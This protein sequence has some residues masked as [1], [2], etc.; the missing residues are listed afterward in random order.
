MTRP[1]SVVLCTYNG[2][3]FLAEQVRSV[4]LQTYPINELIIAD[5]ASTDNTYSLIQELARNDARIKFTRNEFN[6]GFSANFSKAMSSASCELIAISDQDDIWHER[7]LETLVFALADTSSLIY[8]N[9]IHFQGQPIVDPVSNPRNR[10]IEGNDPK[11]IAVF[12]TI[13]GHAMLIRKSLLGMALPVP[14]GVYYDWWLALWAMT[15]GEIQFVPEVLVQQRSHE[16]N[17]TI[18][19]HLSESDLRK[20]F[21]LMLNTHLANFTN[22][23]TFKL[24]D[25]LFFKELNTL[26]AASLKQKLNWKLFIFLMRHRHNIFYYKLR[27]FP[28][29]SQFKHCFLFS[30]RF[31][32]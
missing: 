1:I 29:I 6:L 28:I 19:K 8:C 27:A 18:Q 15:I 14:A 24:S 17:V 21:R 5:D 12:N 26:W 25:Q 7:K 11:K 30:F 2:S 32:L 10:H 3:L 4:L 9:S 22:I 31:Q 13:S 16:N 23:G 20:Q